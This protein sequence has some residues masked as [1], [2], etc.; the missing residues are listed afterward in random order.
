MPFTDYVGREDMRHVFK[1][2]LSAMLR[3]PRSAQD[4]AQEAR[5]CRAMLRMMMLRRLSRETR[6]ATYVD[7]YA[8]VLLFH[9]RHALPRPRSSYAISE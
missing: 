2:R 3:A 1:Q 4:I 5:C 7:A 6:G 8:S 9:A